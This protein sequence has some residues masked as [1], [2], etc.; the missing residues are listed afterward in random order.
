M[1]IQEQKQGAVTV[2]KPMGALVAAEAEMAKNRLQE[3][4]TKSLG[5]VVLDASAI[6]FLDSAGLEV[7]VDV[8]EKLLESGRALK[9]CGANE[10]LRE[11]FELTGWADAFE[12]FADVNSGVR[13]YL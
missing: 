1:D 8:T 13:S 9:V 2:L 10:T 12:H 6:P 5:R 7:L 4:L 11:V 3:A